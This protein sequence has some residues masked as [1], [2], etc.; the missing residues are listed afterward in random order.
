VPRQIVQFTHRRAALRASARPHTRFRIHPPSYILHLPP[1]L[2]A[3]CRV[4]V[5]Y[6]NLPAHRLIL[7]V[8]TLQ[9]TAHTTRQYI[10]SES[11]TARAA[12]RPR[13]RT[14]FYFPSSPLCSLKEP[15]SR[16]NRPTP[17]DF[18]TMQWRK[19]PPAADN[20]HHCERAKRCQGDPAMLPTSGRQPAA[21]HYQIPNCMHG[22]QRHTP[23]KIR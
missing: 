2:P 16:W 8:M 21:G 17:C 7:T 14:L 22:V 6:E 23:G 18:P 4:R 10:L 12:S 13:A 15:H 3:P 1:L 20:R 19:P 5:E 9:K 11:D